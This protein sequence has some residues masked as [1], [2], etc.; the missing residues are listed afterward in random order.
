MPRE[1]QAPERAKGQSASAQVAVRDAVDSD[2]PEI[3]VLYAHHVLNGMASFEIAPPDAAEIGLRRQSTLALG[4]PYLV[5]ELEGSLVGFAYA[6][7]FRP[8]AAYR[9]TV[10]DSVYVA[11]GMSGRGIGSA[12]LAALIERCESGP[13]RQMVAVIGDGTPTSM[14]LHARCGF[15][16]A[17][18]LKDVGFKLGRWSDVVIMQRALG[19]GAARP[20]TEEEAK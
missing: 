20:P 7:A 13:W 11:A 8:R 10:E 19:A 5:A 12:L 6:S 15:V 18:R 16:E 17:A 4:M 1:S 2:L 3:A 9:Y 14:A